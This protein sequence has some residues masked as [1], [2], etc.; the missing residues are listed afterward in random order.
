MI[1][2]QYVQTSP[3]IYRKFEWID[4]EIY[5]LSLFINLQHAQT[6]KTELLSRAMQRDDLW[7]LGLQM[8]VFAYDQTTGKII[9]SDPLSFIAWSITMDGTHGV[10]DVNGITMERGV[11]KTLYPNAFAFYTN[12]YPNPLRDGEPPSIITPIT[13]EIEGASSGNEHLFVS[14][15]KH[16][17][18]C[19]VPA[20]HKLF[21]NI[22]PQNM[23]TS[24]VGVQIF[25]TI[26]YRR[27]KLRKEV[28][29]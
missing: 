28:G 26:S 21:L 27:G 2:N 18:N 7:L 25:G 3:S 24:N 14:R 10:F 4:P 1:S 13:Q 8:T 6:H 19:Y 5:T 29:R 22:E 15:E 9:A 23:S 16:S 12:G 11:G 20:N 17:I